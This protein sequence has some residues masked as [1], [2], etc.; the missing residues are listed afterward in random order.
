MKMNVLFVWLQLCSLYSCYDNDSLDKICVPQECYYPSLRTKNIGHCRSGK[1]LCDK[2]NDYV[3]DQYGILVCDG[4]IA[5]SP[6]VCDGLDNDCD[7]FKD[8]NL[9]MEPKD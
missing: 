9:R 6:E 2:N 5:P 3:K 8:E 7:R 1:T 4:Q